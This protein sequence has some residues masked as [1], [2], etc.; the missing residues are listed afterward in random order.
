MSHYIIR[1]EL[2]S[3]AIQDFLVLH[4]EMENK[5]FERTIKTGLG[6]KYH[7]PRATYRIVTNLD[8][9]SILNQAKESVKV[10][11]RNGEIL[12]IEY[13]NSCWD[14]LKPVN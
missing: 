9:D 5:G 11:G 8:K 4:Q 10:T 13:S 14:G 6:K 2:N 3:E 7:L 1:I 12:V